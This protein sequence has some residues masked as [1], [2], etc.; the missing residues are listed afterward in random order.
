MS[1]FAP[2]LFADDD[3]RN[4]YFKVKGHKPDEKTSAVGVE[5]GEA[6][7]EGSQQMIHP[8]N[9]RS[10]TRAEPKDEPIEAPP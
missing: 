4:Y 9:Q 3:V 10:V 8:W 2:P 5:A 6:A 7:T 1:G